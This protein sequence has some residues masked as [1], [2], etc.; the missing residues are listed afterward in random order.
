MWKSTRHAF[1][2]E[3][4]IIIFY[5]IH[6]SLPRFYCCMWRARKVFSSWGREEKKHFEKCLKIYVTELCCE[7]FSKEEKWKKRNFKELW[8]KNLGHLTQG[9]K[10]FFSKHFFLFFN[11][12]NTNNAMF[13]TENPFNGLSCCLRR[14]F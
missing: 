5:F 13:R 1:L 2:P 6:F 7:S 8:R 4:F 12:I 3:Q 11:S 10:S 14:N 9:Q